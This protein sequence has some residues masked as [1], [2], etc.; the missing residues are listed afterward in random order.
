MQGYEGNTRPVVT[1]EQYRVQAVRPDGSLQVAVL[2][3]RTAEGDVLGE[4]MV[5]PPGY[6]AEHLAL[7]YAS[8]KH[9]V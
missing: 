4:Q 1:R 3:G 8:T 7:G 6:V 2:Q 5:L 9:A